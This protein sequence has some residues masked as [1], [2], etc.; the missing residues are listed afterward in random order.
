MGETIF[1]SESDSA[2]ESHW[3]IGRGTCVSLAKLEGE[4][5][6]LVV[7]WSWLPKSRTSE[8]KLVK[9]ATE[10]ATASG[11]DWVLNHLPKILHA[12]EREFDMDPPQRLS[13]EDCELRVLRIIVQERLY[14]ITELTT[15]AELGE[16]FHGIFKC[17]RWLYEK[18]GIMH[19]D[20]SSNNLMYRRIDGKVYGVL[21]D[22]DLSSQTG[23]TSL[24][25]EQC[26]G[27]QPFM[28]VDL[29]KTDPLPP[30]FYRFDLESLLYVLAYVVCQYHEGEK[31][32][33]PPFDEWDHL[34]TEFLYLTKKAFFFD[35]MMVPPTA[36]FLALQPLTV[37]LH[38]MFADAYSAAYS[39][40]RK[41]VR[42]GSVPITFDNDTLGGHITFD[43]FEEIL[44]AN[45][46]SLT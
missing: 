26:I 6:N 11:D 40:R 2:T 17:Y 35:A 7:K 15:A 1:E 30:H 23:D 32:D 4:E 12:E 3:I 31:I 34:S 21:N 43:K 36:N 41:R 38:E 28:A 44:E 45:L 29:L 42:L 10:L 37:L 22:F 24:T 5:E 9:I 8:A 27:T 19:R 20:I 33:N 18:A 46:P 16:A 39:A 13:G 14:P 25:S